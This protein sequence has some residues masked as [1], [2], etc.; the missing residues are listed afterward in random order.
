MRLIRLA[1]QALSLT[2]VAMLSVAATRAVPGNWNAQVAVTPSGSHVLGNP[3]AQLKL[4][5]YISY[6]CPH[7]AHFDQEA[8]DRLRIYG[9]AQGKLSVEVRHLVRDPIDLTVAML[10][11]CGPPARFF[12]NH[13]TFLRS[14]TQWMATANR[15]TQA[16]QARWTT[17][18][19]KS[20]LQS[21]ASDFGFFPIMAQRGYDR[22][23]VERCLADPV[24]AQKLAAQTAEASRLGVEGTPSF[25]LNG[26]LLAGTHD[27]ASLK[28][29]LDARM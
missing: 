1:A 10:T 21:I 23:T 22:M 18:T 2:S 16:Q 25:L 17:G 12:A 8:S 14:Q 27:W 11:N 29:Q 7:C 28:P 15:A 5:E 6:T 13:T 9:V 19:Q 24:M 20:R 26:A 3:A 4:S